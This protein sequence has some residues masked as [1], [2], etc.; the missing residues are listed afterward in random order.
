MR[1]SA[2]NKQVLLLS[3]HPRSGVF[4]LR[5]LWVYPE[6]FGQSLALDPA[7]QMHSMSLPNNARFKG[8]AITLS[9]RT[10]RC[11]PFCTGT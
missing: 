9:S 3:P 10:A 7:K 6:R 8:Y 1:A 2:V 5:R 11:A 4:D